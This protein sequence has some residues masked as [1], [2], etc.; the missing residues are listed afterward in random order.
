MS[1]EHGF[2]FNTI[3]QNSCATGTLRLTHHPHS[4]AVALQRDI[5]FKFPLQTAVHSKMTRLLISNIQH[6][7]AGPQFHSNTA[8]YP[9]SVCRT[10]TAFL[11]SAHDAMPCV[12]SVQRI[13]TCRDTHGSV[14]GVSHQYGYVTTHLSS[15]LLIPTTLLGNR[16]KCLHVIKFFFLDTRITH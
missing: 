15:S 3:Y 4:T 11:Y 16:T 14:A 7:K 13:M 12:D 5:L 6:S 8:F 10:T 2:L 9:T 1:L